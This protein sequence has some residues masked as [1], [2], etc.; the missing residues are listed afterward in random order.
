[1]NTQSGSDIDTVRAD[2]VR[3]VAN[4]RAFALITLVG[5]CALWLGFT[6]LSVGKRSLTKASAAP[7]PTVVGP[8]SNETSGRFDVSTSDLDAASVTMPGPAAQPVPQP[9]PPTNAVAV[10]A[11]PQP[12]PT[13]QAVGSNAPVPHAI[14]ATTGP[15]AAGTTSAPAEQPTTTP[16]TAESTVGLPAAPPTSH[17]PVTQPPATQPPVAQPTT[18]VPATTATPTTQAPAT[19]AP[20]VTTAAPTTAPQPTAPSGS[21]SYHT[22][23]FTGVATQIVIAQYPDNHISLVSVSPEAG[24]TS[25]V[26]SSGPDTIVVT[27]R[28]A[29]TGG[30]AQ[31]SV[32]HEGSVLRIQKEQ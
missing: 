21:P 19:T 5:A 27:F 8:L 3:T 13:T 23:G 6:V 26:Q 25:H 11:N 30:E 1:M 4:Q 18:P 28:N 10:A 16:T 9:A 15:G 12:T 22:Y 31:F 7:A 32:E 17:P 14:A 20:P 24:W 2:A 29:S